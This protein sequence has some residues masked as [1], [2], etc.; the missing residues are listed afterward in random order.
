MNEPGS[1]TAP[2]LQPSYNELREGFITAAI[3][4]SDLVGDNL[5]IRKEI[6]GS[7]AYNTVQLLEARLTLYQR[8]LKSQEIPDDNDAP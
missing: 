6:V 8:H 4:L 1:Y 3:I 2:G 7:H 5:I